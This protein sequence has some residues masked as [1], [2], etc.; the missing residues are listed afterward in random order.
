MEDC[1]Y[2]EDGRFPLG[3]WN[4]SVFHVHNSSAFVYM[5]RPSKIGKFSKKI[6]KK[7]IHHLG[8]KLLGEFTGEN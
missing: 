6:E 4:L 2:G 5:G 3:T 7:I 8:V 1:A